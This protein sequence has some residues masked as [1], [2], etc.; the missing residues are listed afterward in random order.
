MRGLIGLAVA[1]V[2]MAAPAA[3]QNTAPAVVTFARTSDAL[4]PAARTALDVFAKRYAE[5]QQVTI[6]GHATEGESAAAIRADGGT[7]E[8]AAQSASSFAVGLSQRRAAN[9]RSYLAS[10][11]IPNG[12]MT[13]Q[14][15]GASRPVDPS[16]KPSAAD[17]RV[18]VT[19]GPGSG[20]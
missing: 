18:E 20:W 10:R 9:V 16:G 14:A 3:A 4:T 1:A 15:F 5:G 2:V 11:G 6:S 7:A 17:R 19:E 13:T 12:V 8:E